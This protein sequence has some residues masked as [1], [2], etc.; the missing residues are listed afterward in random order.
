M[1]T[2]NITTHFTWAEAADHEHHDDM[3]HEVVANVARVATMLEKVRE[4]IDG[5][6]LAI[7][8]WYRS[9]KHSIERAKKDGPGAHST[10][11]AVDVHCYNVADAWNLVN[12]AIKAGFTG[13]GIG[14]R[15][16]APR[17]IHMDTVPARQVAPRPAMWSY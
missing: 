16:G 10:G 1:R 17:I 2:G 8:S 12:A 15:K 4:I 14:Q 9:P 11:L 6:P 7:S 3:T 13:I 5:S